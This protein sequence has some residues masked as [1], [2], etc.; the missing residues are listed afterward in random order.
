M[1]SRNGGN[2]A[3]PTRK[4]GCFLHPA[5]SFSLRLR[6]DIHHVLLVPASHLRRLAVTFQTCLLSSSRPLFL[7]SCRYYIARKAALSR[8]FVLY[9]PICAQR[10]MRC[11]R[12]VFGVRLCSP[13]GGGAGGCFAGAGYAGHCDEPRAKIGRWGCRFYGLIS[14]AYKAPAKHP[15]A[16]P[17]PGEHSGPRTPA[18]STWSYVVVVVQVKRTIK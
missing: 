15:P 1:V 9:P 4:T 18:G 17:P 7:C 11:F 16:P 14:I 13:G 12:L 2:P 5:L 8:A 6:S 10:G 3:S